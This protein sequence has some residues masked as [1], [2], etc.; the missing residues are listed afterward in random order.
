MQTDAMDHRFLHLEISLDENHSTSVTGLS[1]P[2]IK[3]LND[4]DDRV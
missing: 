2:F 4:F 3:V 1:Y